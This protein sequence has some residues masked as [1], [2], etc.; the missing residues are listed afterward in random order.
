M[1][2][3]TKFIRQISEELGYQPLDYTQR[4]GW[5][6][7]PEFRSTL[8]IVWDC[9]L[10]LITCLWASL[11]LNVPGPDD[12]P[13]TQ[14]ARKMRWMCV[15]ITFPEVIVGVALVNWWDARHDATVMEKSGFRNWNRN[16]CAFVRM[17]GVLLRA[18]SE[19]YP[20]ATSP[21]SGSHPIVAKPASEQSWPTLPTRTDVPASLL[22]FETGT[23]QTLIQDKLLDQN[24]LTRQMIDDK[25]KGNWFIKLIAC[26]QALYFAMQCVARWGY[27]LPLTT[28]ELSTLCFAVYAFII[29]LLWWHKPVDVCMP[30]VLTISQQALERVSGLY[31]IGLPRPWWHFVEEPPDDVA[32]GASRNLNLRDRRRIPLTLSVTGGVSFALC[33]YPALVGAVLFASLHFLAWNFDFPSQVERYLWRLSC[34]LMVGLPLVNFVFHLPG[35]RWQWAR[36]TQG[37]ILAIYV[38]ARL[39]ILLEGFISLRAAPAGCYYAVNWLTSFP[40]IG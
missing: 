30:V 14:I 5:V 1:Q 31:E 15:A 21:E 17:G 12:T 18:E 8:D 33:I 28:L 32:R 3:S 19:P 10:T 38:I 23:L 25:S 29:Y 13:Y 36:A 35:S 16:L 2:N 34:I 24:G 6:G 22:C 20:V 39:Y 40:H 7:G 9:A 11:H 37:V 26:W 4:V 27:G